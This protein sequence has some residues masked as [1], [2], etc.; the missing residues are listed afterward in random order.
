MAVEAVMSNEDEM[1]IDGIG[2]GQAPR[3]VTPL[4]DAPAK[5]G[6]DAVAA[7][8]GAAP[9]AAAGLSETAQAERFRNLGGLA[10]EL[11]VSAPVDARKVEALREAIA[12]GTYKADPERIAARMLALESGS[13][14]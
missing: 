5:V 9:E 2:R 1:M 6:A 14:R 13:P 11:A 12:S 4:G 10:R 7:R 3:A 8:P